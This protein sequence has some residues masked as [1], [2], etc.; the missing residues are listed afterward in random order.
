MSVF[1]SEQQNKYLA[2]TC[3]HKSLCALQLPSVVLIYTD[4][5]FNFVE[6][7]LH[8][9]AHECRIVWPGQFGHGQFGQ[10]F[11]LGDSLAKPGNILYIEQLHDKHITN[12]QIFKLS[13][14]ICNQ[15]ITLRSV[16]K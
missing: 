3:L 12:E 16:L 2:G 11:R 4:F 10:D 1:F 15:S 8:V 9:C 7:C 5:Y 14:F 6:V 13:M